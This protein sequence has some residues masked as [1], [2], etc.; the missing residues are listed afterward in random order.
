MVYYIN[1]SNLAFHLINDGTFT[2]PVDDDTLIITLDKA[3]NQVL[4]S[5][6]DTAIEPFVVKAGVLEQFDADKKSNILYTAK[7]DYRLF[8]RTITGA[9]TAF[10]R[11]H[12]LPFTGVSPL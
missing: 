12:G 11:G 7:S 5:I 2:Q 3:Q 8:I 6:N 4:V 1:E 10:C 9:I